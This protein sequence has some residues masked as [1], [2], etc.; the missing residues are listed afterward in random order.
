MISKNWFKFSFQSIWVTDRNDLIGRAIWLI[1]LVFIK[2]HQIVR[3][4]NRIASIVPYSYRPWIVVAHVSWY[5]SDR[6]IKERYTPL[7]LMYIY[8]CLR[9]CKDIWLLFIS[10]WQSRVEVSRIVSQMLKSNF[11]VSIT[12]YWFDTSNFAWKQGD[13]N[14]VTVSV[15][16]TYRAAVTSA[17]TALVK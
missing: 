4:L 12:V 10:W 5:V 8:G 13:G 16:Q 14:A 2:L 6:P 3:T 9:E 15:D 1:W 11:G 7:V 17:A